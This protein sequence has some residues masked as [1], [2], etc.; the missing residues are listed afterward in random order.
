MMFKQ[1]EMSKDQDVLTS[2]S[3]YVYLFVYASFAYRH[4]QIET[5]KFS[6]LLICMRSR[7]LNQYL[8][9]NA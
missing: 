9:K 7:S 1:N 2:V 3:Q 5:G 8:N 4:N 6:V